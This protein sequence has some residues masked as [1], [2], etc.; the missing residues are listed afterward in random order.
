[1][2]AWPK[3]RLAEV[4]RRVKR[5]ESR[6]ELTEY[7][8]AGT[9]SFARGIFVGERKLGST[10]ALPKIQRVRQGDFVY[11]KIMAWDGA[12]GLVPSEADNCV[13]SG[14]FVAYELNRDRIDER[15]L[16]YFFKVPAHWQSIGSQS[17]GTNV[18]RQS[19]HPNQ[20]EAAE[21]P[22][23]PLAEQRRVVALIEELAAQI[24]E[25]HTLRQQASEEAEALTPRAAA[26]IFDKDL[27]R[28]RLGNVSEFINGDRGKNYP[29][30]VEY[31]PEGV[32]WINTG[33]IEP[34]GSLSL[35]WMH[36]ITREKFDSL[37]SGKVR[38]GDL[39]YCLRGAT[40]GKTAIITQF[41]EGAV[42]SSLVII[43]PST[44]LDS[45]FAYWFLISPQGREE[46]F[47]FDNG[48]AQPNLSADSVKKYWIPLPSLTEQRRIVAELDALHAE[49]D[50]LKRL[51][52][53][54]AAELDALLPAILDRA[55]KG[56]LMSREQVE[57]PSNRG[58]PVKGL[59][60]HSRRFIRAVFAAEVA[61]RL[62][63]ERTFGQVKFQKA[64]FLAE[65]AAQVLEIDS[66]AQRFQNGPHDPELIR[67]VEEE[68]KA[69]D[70][71]ESYSRS[72]DRPGHAY[73]ALGRAGEH[74]PYFEQFW[75]ENAA[76]I[77]RVI[78]V[79]L[80][81]DTERCERLATVYAA[82]NDLII[83]NRPVADAAIL[84]EILVRWHPAKLSIPKAKWQE[85][86]AWVRENDLVPT[87]F[88]AATGE[89]PQSELF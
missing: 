71:F 77:R 48:S 31:V 56:E 69:H 36:Y 62:H 2:S 21:I 4:L 57:I 72:D 59:A 81:W 79:L 42:A 84:S 78:D 45:R 40:L 29:N 6:D 87:G 37:R 65:Y 85:T 10:F 35:Q 51:Q 25:A 73:R 24:H 47:Q 7:P 64:L 30:K 68:M 83:W 88:G 46:I 18:R 60:Q 70:W 3:V 12:F 11:C 19:L 89:T 27:P 55:F 28:A 9:Y 44:E 53:E 41:K 8:F 80:K 16:D 38:P 5:F 26:K 66:R 32:P 1:M 23:P 39:V 13:M 58:A 34:D 15:F 20:F 63:R 49:V 61:M 76:A 75:P 22:L 86:I 33:H 17:S 67:E 54:T 82:W 50:A 43:R 74:T 14:A 52:A